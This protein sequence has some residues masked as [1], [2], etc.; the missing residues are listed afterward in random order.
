M[1]SLSRRFDLVTESGIQKYRS[2]MEEAT[3][4]IVRYDGSFSGEHG[5]GQSRAEFLGK[6]FGPELIG[7]FRGFKSIWDPDWKMNPGKIVDPYRIDE[8]LRLGAGYKPWEPKTHFKFPDDQG[9]FARATLRC[10]GVGKCRRLEGSGRA[11]HHVSKFYGYA[12]REG[13]DTRA[14]PCAV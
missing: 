6:M 7:A 3:D 9:S 12:R 14:G 2:F 4:L 8:N 13:Y 10:V 5:D 1:H 11:C